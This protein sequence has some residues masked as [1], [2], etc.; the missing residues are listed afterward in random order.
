MIASDAAD[1]LRESEPS[2]A[3]QSMR[4]PV[5]ERLIGP[6]I[7]RGSYLRDLAQSGQV[8]GTIDLFPQETLS[9]QSPFY[10]EALVP[11]VSLFPAEFHDLRRRTSIRVPVKLH[12]L[13]NVAV[14]GRDGLCVC[15]DRLILDSAES[16]EP[17]RRESLIAQRYHQDS[18]VLKHAVMC[19]PPGPAPLMIGFTGTWRNYAHWI[20]ECL[21][22]A[23]GFLQLRQQVPEAKLLLPPLSEDSPQLSTIRRLGIGA[24]DV[25]MMQ[26]DD[27]I[28]AQR[29]WIM[30][31]FHIW[32]PPRLCRTSA[33]R[34]SIEIPLDMRE[35]EGSLPERLYIQ[36]GVPNIRQLIN[37]EELRPILD[38]LGFTVLR[39]QDLSL[40]DQVRTLRNARFV[41]GENSGGLANIMFCRRGTRV[42]EL[43]NP[44]FPHPAHWALAS[45]IGADY[46]FCVGKH[47]GQEPSN[48]NSN[49]IIE[50]DR[51][52][53]AMEALTAGA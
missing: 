22:R 1:E 45:L 29:L 30:T 25:A 15:K 53:R 23:I 18:L 19:S 34:L 8:A 33:L 14:V 39:M 41:V 51:F 6:R 38:A 26:G 9:R 11:G 20:T 43:N 47:V 21:P 31:S 48:M 52:T 24:N 3:S 17:W 27:V 42:L 12:C 16:I 2:H 37:F 10:E 32:H 40:D 44:A 4:S 46:G 49:Y 36:R 13:E 35:A 5:A 28:H 7:V 50:P